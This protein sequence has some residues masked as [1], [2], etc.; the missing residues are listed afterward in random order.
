LGGPEY[1]NIPAQLPAT[2]Q[3]NERYKTTASIMQI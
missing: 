2:A 1:Q 3:V